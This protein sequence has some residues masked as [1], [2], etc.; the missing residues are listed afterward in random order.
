MALEVGEE[1]NKAEIAWP[2]KTQEGVGRSSSPQKVEI[3]S[4]DL[5]AALGTGRTLCRHLLIACMATA[6]R[7]VPRKK[8]SSSD[9]REELCQGACQCRSIWFQSVVL[10]SSS[11]GLL[12]QVVLQLLTASNKH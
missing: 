12:L 8:E 9:R 7:D 11:W 2:K 6:L 1:L 4:G 10:A 3:G 5:L